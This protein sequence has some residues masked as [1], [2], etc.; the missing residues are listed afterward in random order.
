VVFSFI[1]E[2]VKN[3]VAGFIP[4]SVGDKPREGGILPNSAWHVKNVAAGF[5]P[6]S[7]FRIA[8]ADRVSLA[9]TVGNVIAGGRK[10]PIYW[11]RKA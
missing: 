1:I 2:S 9:M 6:A 5:I 4:A 11:A 3:V 10:L 7:P 8:S